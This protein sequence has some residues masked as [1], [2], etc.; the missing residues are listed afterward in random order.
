MARIFYCGG[1]FGGMGTLRAIVSPSDLAEVLE[2]GA[3]F[4]GCSFPDLRQ[5]TA[6]TVIEILLGEQDAN[7]RAGFYLLRSAPVDFEGRLRSYYEAQGR[8]I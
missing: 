3:E 4:V 1:T 8:K 7:R 5:E 6:C 2:R